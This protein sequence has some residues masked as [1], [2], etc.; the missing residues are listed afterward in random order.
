MLI[1]WRVPKT[2]QWIVK[3]FLIY[4]V[5]F[6]GFR[7]ATVVCFKPAKTGLWEDRKSVV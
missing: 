5:I 1:K 3:L 6:T 7:V 4:L 2:I